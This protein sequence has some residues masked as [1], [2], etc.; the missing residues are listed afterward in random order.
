MRFTIEKKNDINVIALQGDL[1]GG[2]DTFQLIFRLR[3]K[4][5]E[6][7]A[8]GDRKFII[9]LKKTNRVNS[10]GIGL[11]V[12]VL[13]SV[14]NAGGEVKICEVG[15]RVRTSMVVTGVTQLF[16]TYDTLEEAVEAFA[17]SV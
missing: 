10:A 12:A 4:V 5:T 17:V 8:D 11:L 7:T 16:E 13:A 1:W 9:D 3:E 14:K 15:R 2:E 6:L